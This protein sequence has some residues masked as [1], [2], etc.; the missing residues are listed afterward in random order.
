MIIVIDMNLEWGNFPP[1]FYTKYGKKQAK[2]TP[3]R[4]NPYH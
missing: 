4:T 3:I 2:Q 1:L